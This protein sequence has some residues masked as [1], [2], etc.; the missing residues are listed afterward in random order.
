MK[1]MRLY[2]EI[3]SMVIILCGFQV[4]NLFYR[5]YLNCLCVSNIVY[6][7]F[8]DQEVYNLRMKYNL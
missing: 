6:S 4:V 1:V 7:F 3:V 5:Y 8:K 2:K